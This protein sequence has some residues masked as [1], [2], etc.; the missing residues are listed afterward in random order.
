MSI[1]STKYIR[2]PNIYQKAFPP[3][4]LKV[5]PT[6]IIEVSSHSY[7]K[8]IPDSAAAKVFLVL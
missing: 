2:I 7:G 3:T 4:L 6:H 8:Y 5:V 1:G